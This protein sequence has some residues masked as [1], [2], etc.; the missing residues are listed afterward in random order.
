M[1]RLVTPIVAL[2]LLLSACAA[3]GVVDAGPGPGGPTPNS[4]SPKSSK[5]STSPSPSPS[6]GGKTFTYQLWFTY[7]EH[8]FVTKRTEPFT[9]SVGATSLRALMGG[10]SGQE[11]AAGVGT[12]VPPDTTYLGL[13]ISNGV[14]TVD[15][16]QEFESGGGTL[17]VSMRLAQV[18]YTITQYPSV[19]S[20][21]FRLDG[22]PVKV[23][24]GDGFIL[25]HPVT[26]S[27]YEDLLPPILVERPLIGQRVASPVSISGTANVFEATVSIRILDEDG[28]VIAEAFT[29]AAC[30]TGCR[31]TYSKDVA[32]HV[33]HDQPGTVMVFESSA[34]NGEPINVVKIPVTLTA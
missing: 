12:A 13:S 5:P 1:K 11:S 32:Y 30:G 9:P 20:V 18:V 22:V 2:G 7:G 19:D 25:D 29:T 15:L 23:F 8:L 24:T 34:E 21:N 33:D 10:P 3:K 17:S 27:D 31:G 6:S 28:K 16:S 14:A 4:P 26:R